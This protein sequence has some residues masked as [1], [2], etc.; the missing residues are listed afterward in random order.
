MRRGSSISTR[1]RLPNRTNWIRR[2]YD[3]TSAARDA[4][5]S[6][7]IPAYEDV[8]GIRRRETYSLV[9]LVA[10][11]RGSGSDRDCPFCGNGPVVDD[12][13]VHWLSMRDRNTVRGFTFYE[14]GETPGLGG[15]VDNPKW[16]EVVG[17]PR[18]L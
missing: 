7:V 17:R 12:V 6:E 18:G 8:A 4:E 15:E 14:H 1:E 9:Y 3:Q 11:R 5:L 2:Q 16:K 10:R 13:R